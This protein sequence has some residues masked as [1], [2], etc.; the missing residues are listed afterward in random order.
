M[1]LTNIKIAMEISTR[2]PIR[3]QQAVSRFL[4]RTDTKW[5]GPRVDAFSKV[6]GKSQVLETCIRKREEV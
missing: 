3:G 5:I 1:C 4:W 6:N 2:F